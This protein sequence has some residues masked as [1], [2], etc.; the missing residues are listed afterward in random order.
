MGATAGANRKYAVRVRL[1]WLDAT[2]PVLPSQPKSLDGQ[3]PVCAYVQRFTH[4]PRPS[5][6]H[7]GGRAKLLARPHARAAVY[8]NTSVAHVGAQG[9]QQS[10][11][12]LA[13]LTAH[14]RLVDTPQL[15]TPVV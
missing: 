3:G 2:L 8:P 9:V 13:G 5:L 14:P 4:T 6:V 11:R 7:A 1:S 15:A 12:H 10:K